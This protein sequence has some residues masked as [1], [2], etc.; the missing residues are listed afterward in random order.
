M[1][2]KSIKKNYFYNVSYQILTLITPL[3]TTP[4]ISRVLGADGVGTISYVESIASYF[5]LFA[6]MGIA[7]HGQREISYV[8]DDV[9]KR[10]LVFWNTKVL[11]FITSLLALA[12]Y[13]VFALSRMDSVIYLIFAF[14]LLSVFADVSWFFQGMEDF[15]R[16]VLRNLVFKCINIAYLFL[17]VRTKEDIYVYALG[18]SFFLFL[19]NASLWAS[20]PK[21]VK[22]VPIRSLHPFR[23]FKVVLSLFLPTIAIQIYAVLDKTMIGV[24]T[25]SS[26]ENGYYEQALKISKLVLTIVTSLGTVM[27][28]RIGFHFENGDTKEVQCLM[29]RGYRFVWMTGI[30]LCFGLTMVSDNL[31]PW[32]FG[33]GYDKVA[34]LLKIL[35][36]LIL[37]IGINNVTGMQYLIPTKKQNTFT[38]TVIIGAV[39]NLILNSFLIRAFASTGAAVATVA[40]ESTIAVVQLI[41]VRK[42]LSP[43]RVLKEGVHY[44]IA[45]GAMCLMLWLVGRN[46]SATIRNTVLLVIIGVVTYGAVV[47][48][49]RDEFVLSNIRTVVNHQ[50]KRKMK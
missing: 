45:G 46:M 32:F 14:N 43:F 21:F 40:A 48:L 28:P 18:L 41:I 26:F 27:I 36:F 49:E 30:P 20:L 50:R 16:I 34:D 9:E 7:I 29:Y 22:R 42:E 25:Q 4:Y 23:A 8:Q 11:Q 5:T 44:F 37:A 2:R 17:M 1:A 47:L 31:V 38:L 10:S 24:I 13:V 6:T 33:A 15:K 35:S 19:S 3:I 12:G 39:V